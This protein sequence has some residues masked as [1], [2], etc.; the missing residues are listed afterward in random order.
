MGSGGT[1]QDQDGQ[2]EAH[3]GQILTDDINLFRFPGG[4]IN[5]TPKGNKV[6]LLR[7]LVSGTSRRTSHWQ[8]LRVGP[9]LT[10]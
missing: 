5:N 3:S 4:G 6:D 9:G 1:H 8:C 10:V 2:D 7:F